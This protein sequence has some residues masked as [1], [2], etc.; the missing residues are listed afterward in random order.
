MLSSVHAM[1]TIGQKTI[2]KNVEKQEMRDQHKGWSRWWRTVSSKR[3]GTTGVPLLRDSLIRFLKSDITCSP[4]QAETQT[5]DQSVR[6]RQTGTETVSHREWTG[7]VIK[8]FG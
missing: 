4:I 7:A 5:N 3:G 6:E 1:T 2:D 8:W